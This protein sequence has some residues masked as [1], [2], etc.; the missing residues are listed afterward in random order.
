MMQCFMKKEDKSLIDVENVETT[1][2]DNCA[3]FAALASFL[4]VLF[5]PSQSCFYR[6]LP[7][8]CVHC[9]IL[10]VLSVSASLRLRAQIEIGVV[11]V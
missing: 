2:F 6:I 3:F 8:G 4:L 10:S 11:A 9:I 7:L 5:H 1:Y